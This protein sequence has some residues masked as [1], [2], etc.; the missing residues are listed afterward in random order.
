M[1]AFAGLQQPPTPWRGQQQSGRRIRVA[2][3]CR[4]TATAPAHVRREAVGRQDGGRWLR[5]HREPAN[6]GLRAALCRGL[7]AGGAPGEDIFPTLEMRPSGSGSGRMGFRPPH[8]IWGFL[9]SVP[10][11]APWARKPATTTKPSRVPEVLCGQQPRGQLLAGMD[12][13]YQAD[14]VDVWPK[15]P[16]R[17]RG[18]RL[19]TSRR[20]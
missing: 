16:G 3:G 4:W 9:K 15:P 12:E 8:W 11:S 1:P 2:G 7:T 14:G 18:A 20:L 5:D 17:V 6:T 10:V 19:G 13:D